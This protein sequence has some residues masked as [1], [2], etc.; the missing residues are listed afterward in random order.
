[1]AKFWFLVKE[2]NG[3]DVHELQCLLSQLSNLDGKPTAIICHT[4][5]GKGVRFA[6]D[7]NEWHHK[8][9][10]SVDVVQSLYDA[11]ESF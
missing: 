2:A 8:N 9:N 7:N 5:K 6:E 10:L 1:M 11:L 3:H 4:V